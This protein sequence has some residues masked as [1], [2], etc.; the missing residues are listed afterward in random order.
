MD[1][2]VCGNPTPRVDR[3]YCSMECYKAHQSSLTPTPDPT[4]E[5]IAARCREIQEEWDPDTEQ[6]RASPSMRTVRWS[7]PGSR[8]CGIG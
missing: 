4:P 7:V 8:I 3:K 6:L 1:C 5:E 2:P